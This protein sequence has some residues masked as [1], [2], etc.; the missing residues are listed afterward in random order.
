MITNIDT[1]LFYILLTILLLIYYGKSVLKPYLY[2]HSFALL[3][4]TDTN[5]NTD[6]P[7]NAKYIH[8]QK[9]VSLSIY[10]NIC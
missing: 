3:D 10:S 7:N 9:I 1:S 5:K 8:V 2:M 6:L 4:F